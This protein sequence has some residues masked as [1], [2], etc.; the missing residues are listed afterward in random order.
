MRIFAVLAIV[1]SILSVPGCNEPPLYR[2]RARAFL[3]QQNVAPATIAKL[4]EIRPLTGR[5]SAML[6]QFDSVPVLHLL[7]ANPSL[8][9][10]MVERLAKHPDYEVRTGLATNPKAPLELLMG[11]RTPG[12]YTTLN[13][14]LARNPRIPKAILWE[15]Y[16][17]GEAGLTSFALNPNSPTRLLFRIAD[18]GSEVDRAWLATNPSLPEALMS[19]LERDGSRVV[20]RYLE[21]NP[22]YKKPRKGGNDTS[23]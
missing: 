5:E 12:R 21:T 14:S 16:E 20:R 8:P 9:R 6:A 4:V 13:N 18:E 1:L 23:G 3:E 10:P 11:F 19:R 17:N 2:Q 7:G 15:M 22:A